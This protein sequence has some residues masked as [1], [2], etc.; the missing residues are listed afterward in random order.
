[1]TD[2]PIAC[3]LSA[4]DAEQRERREALFQRFAQ[5]VEETQELENGYAF[6]CRMDSSNWMTAAEFADLE[7]RCCPFFEFTLQIMPASSS[8]WLQLTGGAGT[9]QFLTEQLI[10]EL[11]H[12]E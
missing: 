8:M 7:R 12:H 11:L 2:K 6:R 3:N 1:M 9:K 4:L 10:G 5:R